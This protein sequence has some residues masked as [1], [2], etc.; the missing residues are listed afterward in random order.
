MRILFCCEFYAPSV[1]G[2]QEVMRQLAERLVLKG[3]QV[4]VATSALPDRDF[5]TLNGVHIQEFAVS[6]NLVR[7]ILGEDD[8]YRDFVI[9]G[10]FDV[11]MIKAAQ[12]WTFDAL[13]SVLDQIKIPKVFIPCGFSGLMEPSFADYFSRMPIILRK[14]DHLIFYASDYRDINFAKQHGIM[15]F[16]VVPNGASEWEFNVEPDTTFRSRN[17]ISSDAFVFLTVGSFTGLKGHL[18]LVRAFKK[19]NM[20]KGMNAVLILNGNDCL[21]LE[22]DLGTWL[23]KLNGLVRCYGLYYTSKHVLKDLLRRVGIAGTVSKGFKEIAA[24]INREDKN[25]KV[26]V[27]NFAR[28]ELIQAYMASD[29][30]V[31]ASNIEYSP[32]VLFESAAAGLPFLSV[33]VGNAQEIASWTLSGELCISE[34]D[35]KGYTRVDTNVLA[36]KMAQM[37]GRGAELKK[38]GGRGKASWSNN[39]TWLKISEQYEKIFEGLVKRSS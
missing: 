33:D 36:E 24:S 34:R 25:K 39:F 30:F 12:Q 14:F 17:S 2:V 23:R 18:E 13:W 10:G 28:P 37:M 1:G 6:G 8:K 15:N 7:G 27:T 29:L 9:N 20:A 22:D 5:A 19:L 26:L 31:F 11:M 4:T 3:H 38:M 35:A 21:G 32:L 16:S